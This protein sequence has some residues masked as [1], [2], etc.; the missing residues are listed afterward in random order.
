M[1]DLLKIMGTEKGSS[2]LDTPH[3][4]AL[5]SPGTTWL[6]EWPGPR[7]GSQGSVGSVAAS[8][9]LSTGQKGNWNSSAACKLPPSGKPLVHG[10][11]Q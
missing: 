11:F 7:A 3:H 9:E 8:A 6:S 5:R 2:P 1:P 10:T 4:T